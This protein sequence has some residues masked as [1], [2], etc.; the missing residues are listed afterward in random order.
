MADLVTING[1]NDAV[2]YVWGM[3]D[4]LGRA[5]AAFSVDGQGQVIDGIVLTAE[6]HTVDDALTYVLLGRLDLCHPRQVVL[7]SSWT[8]RDLRACADADAVTYRGVS[9]RC[10]GHDAE[11]LDWV[12][13]DG[14]VFR[15]LRLALDPDATWPTL[16]DAA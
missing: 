3:H 1:F 13:Y 5:N 14:A 7:L 9:A 2:A 4:D 8:D 16:G 10:A 6:H 11:L 12:Q 15:S